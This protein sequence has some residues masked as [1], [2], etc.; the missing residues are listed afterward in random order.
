MLQTF[1]LYAKSVIQTF[2]CSYKVSE[3]HVINMLMVN[4]CELVDSALGWRIDI[5]RQAIYIIRD[6]QY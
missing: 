1:Q 4:A 5:S 3:V 2:E 6:P